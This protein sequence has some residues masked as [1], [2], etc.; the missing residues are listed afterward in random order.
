MF[1]NNKFDLSKKIKFT[2]L[3]KNIRILNIKKKKYIF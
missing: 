1:Y 2:K 3:K